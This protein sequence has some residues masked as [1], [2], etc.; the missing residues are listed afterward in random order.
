[1]KTLVY[2]IIFLVYRRL[3]VVDEIASENWVFLFPCQ[4]MNLKGLLHSRETSF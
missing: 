3:V 2:W 4:H 1:M